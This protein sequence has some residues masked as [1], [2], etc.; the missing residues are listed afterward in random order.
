MELTELKL[1]VKILDQ[2]KYGARGTESMLIDQGIQRIKD[3]SNLKTP[4]KV[5]ACYGT[6]FRG[7]LREI[8]Y[9]ICL[10]GIIEPFKEISKYNPDKTQLNGKAHTFYSLFGCK[11]LEGKLR[12]SD[13]KFKN[14]SY[15][16]EK[17]D[18]EPIEIRTN[19]S[20][21]SGTHSN[22]KNSLFHYEV[23]M[24]DEIEYNIIGYNLKEKEKIL[25]LASLMRLPGKAIGGKGSSGAGII[26]KT[27]GFEDFKLEILPLI[28][29]KVNSQNGG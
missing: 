17:N 18:M 2:Y 22:K 9:D 3:Y 25:L 1:K 20:I 23:A 12:I 8:A 16:S 28:K 15:H 26:L 14:S 5:I 4:K 7:L 11:G 19:T 21:F 24:I 10:S 27:T 29:K 6:P 13:G